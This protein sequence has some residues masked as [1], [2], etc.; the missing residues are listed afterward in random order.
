MKRHNKPVPNSGS[1]RRPFSK[2]LRPSFEVLED[3]QLL[4]ASFVPSISASLENG[5]LRINGTY[6]SDTIQV[7]QINNQLSVVGVYGS[8]SAGQVQKL[9]IAGGGGNDRVYLNSEEL[10]GQQ[11]IAVPCLVR[12]GAG[13]DSIT[14]STAGDFLFGESG[15][16]QIS[17]M[18]GSDY[19]DGGSGN[20][21]LYGQAGADKMYGDLGGDSIYGGASSDYLVGGDD[22]DWLFGGTEADFLDG[23]RGADRIYGEAGYDYVFDDATGNTISDSSMNRSVGHC[24]WFDMKIDDAALRSQSRFLA[25]DLN[26]DRADMLQVFQQVEGGGTVSSIEFGDLKD[27]VA[28]G[29]FAPGMPEHVRNLTKKV[30]NGDTANAHYLGNTL[31]NLYANAPASHLEKLVNKWFLGLDR[32]VTSAGTYRPVNGLLVQNGINFHDVAQGSVG[33][34]YY[35]AALAKTA[36]RTSHT[37]ET[38]F[39]DNLDNTFTVRF[40]KNGVAE[41]VTVDRQLPVNSN[42]TSVYASFGGH[43]NNASNELWVAL[44]EKAY[45]QL[46]ES[47]WIGQDGTNS[48]AGIDVGK[49]ADAMKQI[50]GRNATGYATLSKTSVIAAFNAG[51]L[52]AFSSKK[53]QADIPSSVG[54]VA[55]HVYALVGYNPTTQKFTLYNPWGSEL[56]LSWTQMTQGFRAWHYT[57]T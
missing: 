15:V 18:N 40:Y 27:L 23:S 11:A 32:P 17:G 22:N 41:Y 44:A 47:G 30:V 16:D 34:C 8:F 10:A 12:G 57:H 31:G 2:A 33:D 54:V 24:G 21:L 29:S 4:A 28:G 1:N 43:Y 3:R 53:D 51:K 50:T 19:V 39:I 45:A 38:M 14:G 48:Y 5:I 49:P 7:R 42:G 52:V 55:H 20:D 13:N 37:I 35:L 36:Y 25:R 46:N 6:L 26:L 56:T 9:E